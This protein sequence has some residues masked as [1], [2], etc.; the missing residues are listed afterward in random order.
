MSLPP[1]GQLSLAVPGSA[2]PPPHAP[3]SQVWCPH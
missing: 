3:P 2:C 1:L